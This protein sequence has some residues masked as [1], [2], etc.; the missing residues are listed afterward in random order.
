[1]GNPGTTMALQS[2]DGHPANTLSS[3]QIVFFIGHN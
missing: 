3:R 2:L 1:M